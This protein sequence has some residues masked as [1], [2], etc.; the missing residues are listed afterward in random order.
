[1]ARGVSTILPL[2][3]KPR[4]SRY[5]LEPKGIISNHVK[6]A[7]QFDT[8]R[9]CRQPAN[10]AKV[11]SN[12]ALEDPG[13]VVV[14]DSPWKRSRRQAWRRLSEHCVK[15]LGFVVHFFCCSNK[16]KGLLC[17]FAL[18]AARHTVRNVRPYPLPYGWF[19]LTLS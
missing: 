10:K 13:T 19:K 17:M 12:N 11:E 15:T 9:I 16:K 2:Q 4:F 5:A 8:K 14:E 3:P 18:G 7:V 1:M 6:P